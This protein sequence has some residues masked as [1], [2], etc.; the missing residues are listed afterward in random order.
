MQKE[1]RNCEKTCVVVSLVQLLWVMETDGFQMFPNT[2]C[3][4]RLSKLRHMM[5]TQSALQTGTQ[6]GHCFSCLMENSLWLFCDSSFLFWG[7]LWFVIIK[8]CYK[9]HEKSY[10]RVLFW[11]CLYCHIE[12]CFIEGVKVKWEI[13]AVMHAFV[14]CLSVVGS[15][16]RGG[17]Y[18]CMH[19]IVYLCV[20][21][22]MCC[23]P[24]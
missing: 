17:G 22:W 1:E 11:G 8:Q 4:C 15:G 13:D 10:W 5:L 24:L 19:A 16:G 21:M 7:V 23:R 2:E 20:L 3:G 18:K 12:Q 6:S 14:M 9:L